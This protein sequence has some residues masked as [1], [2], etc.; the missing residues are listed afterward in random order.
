M[1]EMWSQPLQQ[2]KHFVYL[3]QKLALKLMQN[4]IHDSGHVLKE[5]PVRAHEVEMLTVPVG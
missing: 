2:K 3:E 1:K 4:C 5:I